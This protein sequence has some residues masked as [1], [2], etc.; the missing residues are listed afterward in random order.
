M[1][2]QSLRGL[3]FDEDNVKDNEIRKLR[4]QNEI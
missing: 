1:I 2:Q 4:G 3:Y